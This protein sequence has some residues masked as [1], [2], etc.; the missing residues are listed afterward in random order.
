MAFREGQACVVASVGWDRDRDRRR[1]AAVSRRPCQVARRKCLIY[2]VCAAAAVEVVVGLGR[3]EEVR[4]TLV[5]VRAEAAC[6]FV[7]A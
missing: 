5:L 6:L 2:R 4:D 3:L 1:V 7:V